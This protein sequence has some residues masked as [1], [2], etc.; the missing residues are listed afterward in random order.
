M[1]NYV[2]FKLLQDYIHPPFWW[3]YTASAKIHDENYQTGGT[4]TDRLKADLGFFWRILED[5]NQIKDTWQKRKAVYT[6]I[7]Y[8]I[9]VRMFGWI[10]FNKK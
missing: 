7:L 10:S 5:A 1:R 2:G 9:L 6:A 8:F 4:R 3:L